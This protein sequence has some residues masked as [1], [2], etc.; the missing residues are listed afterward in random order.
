[1][2]CN[3]I[4]LTIYIGYDII[5]AK[6]NDI[7]LHTPQ[8]LRLK[9]LERDGYKCQKCGYNENLKRLQVHHILAQKHGGQHDEN[10]LITLCL[11]CHRIA[12][13][14][15]ILD[16]VQRYKERISNEEK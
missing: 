3:Y 14:Q 13:K 4:E 9:I 16:A 6:N 15:I 2:A 1:M 8:K 10:N 11:V 7:L 12:D 5:N